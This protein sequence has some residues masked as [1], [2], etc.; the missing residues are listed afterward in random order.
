MGLHS[1]VKGTLSGGAIEGLKDM[2]S[3]HCCP[4]TVI[5]VIIFF[6][7]KVSQKRGGLGSQDISSPGERRT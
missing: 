6:I 2:V 4:I 1:V 3:L 5:T 7:V